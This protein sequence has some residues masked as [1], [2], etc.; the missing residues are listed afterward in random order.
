MG[1]KEGMCSLNDSLLEL[2]SKNIVEAPEAYQRAIAKEEFLKRM[3][4]LP[5]CRS[6]QGKPWTEEELLQAAEGT[7][8]F[9]AA[10]GNGT[11]QTPAERAAAYR[12]PELVV[13]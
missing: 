12:V 11:A 4:S 2:V 1:R 5:N 3:G 13:N 8:P 6:P 10:K 9:V 7:E